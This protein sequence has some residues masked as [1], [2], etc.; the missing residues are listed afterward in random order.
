MATVETKD[1]GKSPVA[2]LQAS[3]LGELGTSHM[4][5]VDH[6]P[7]GMNSWLGD[8]LRR[9]TQS[10]P[11]VSENPPIGKTPSQV[12]QG[13]GSGNGVSSPD[14]YYSRNRQAVL[15]AGG[16]DL[17]EPT[18]GFASTPKPLLTRWGT[19]QGEAATAALN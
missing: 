7:T 18:N 5:I 11:I 1:D 2:T 10:P 3:D 19:A 13:I 17:P 14:T 12:L 8:A 6:A 16:T 9:V 15:N 4:T